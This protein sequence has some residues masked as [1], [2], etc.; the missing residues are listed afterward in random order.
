M[1]RAIT[2]VALATAMAC[3]FASGCKNDADKSSATRTSATPSTSAS[4]STNASTSTSAAASA[5]P[6]SFTGSYTATRGT[7]YVPDAEAWGGVKFRGDDGG[8][9]LGEGTLTFT[10]DGDA[11]ALSGELQ[12]PLGP[13]TLTGTAQ[14]GVVAFHVAPRETTDMAF[15]GTG[16]GDVDGGVASGEL[17][18]SSWR[19]NVLRDATFQAKRK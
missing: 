16:T 10:I 9:A 13:A 18:V 12:G 4:A 8:N 14:N 7:L 17:H 15:S 19:A 1:L 5:G 11:G 6:A 3:A 2:F